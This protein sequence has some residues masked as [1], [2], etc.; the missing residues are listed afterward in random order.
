MESQ[1]N[2]HFGE[3]SSSS[4]SNSSAAYPANSSSD[5]SSATA[6]PYKPK[7]HN[8][9]K[10]D[11]SKTTPLVVPQ[12]LPVGNGPSTPSTPSTPSFFSTNAGQLVSWAAPMTHN[13]NLI[14]LPLQ[15]PQIIEER[16]SKIISDNEA[17]I[18][19]VEPSLQKKYHKITGIQRHLS[20]SSAPSCVSPFS[21]GSELPMQSNSKLAL[22][23]LK[24]QQ[25]QKQH[26]EEILRYQMSTQQP[27]NLIK[28]HEPLTVDVGTSVSST[29][30]RKRYLT[31]NPAPLV[32]TT[33]LQQPQEIAAEKPAQST[34]LVIPA[35]HPQNPE[36]SII[37]DLLL[38][39]KNFGAVD[40]ETGDGSYTCPT[41][42]LSFRGA[43]ILKYH[44]ICHC[45]GEDNILSRSAPISPSGTSSPYYPRS[46]SEKQS[47]ITLSQLA[48]SS[49]RAGSSRT[50]SSLQKLAKSQ[51]KP[52]KH[53]PDNININSAISAIKPSIHQ[54][55]V[56]K[57][58]LPS[59]GPLLGNT[60]LVDKRLD[61]EIGASSAKKQKVEFLDSKLHQLF[62]GDM[63]IF[64]EKMLQNS[65]NFQ[66]GS[67]IAVDNSPLE[68]IKE[69]SPNMMRQGL[70]GGIALELKK[71]SPTTPVGPPPVT[72]KLFVTITPT[73]AP[74]LT[75]NSMH[76]TSSKS[77]NHF[78]F[79]SSVTVY[80]P[81]TLPLM[82][83]AASSVIGTQSIVHGGRVIPYVPGIPGPNSTS[84]VNKH[85][86]PPPPVPVKD[87]RL[88]S[89]SLKQN[90]LLLSP[91]DP[92]QIMPRPNGVFTKK[93]SFNF[94][95]IAD[96]IDSRADKKASDEP[97]DIK[98]PEIKPT[99]PAF[100]RPNTL[101]LK[102]GTFTPKQHHGI[103]PTANT[104]PLISPET[105]RPSKSCVQMYLNGHAYTYLG[106]KSST[107]T[108]YC[109]V[110]KPQPV[111]IQNQHNLSMYSNWQIY[112]GNN[113]NILDLP[114]FAA[115][116]L[117][118]SR[119]RPANFSVAAAE[120]D[121]VSLVEM[122]STKV[123]TTVAPTNFQIQHVPMIKEEN[124]GQSS[125]SG[126]SSV[127]G[128]ENSEEYTYIR[129]RGRGKYVCEECGIRCKKPSMLKKHIRT[130]T[131]LRPYTCSHCE[132]R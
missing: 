5:N 20:T 126:G 27:L 51:L 121:I 76:F 34:Q 100:L 46:N 47:P 25:Q 71:E 111:Y 114:P 104:L 132:F 57:N 123:T 95:R 15:T 11:L 7:F 53:K 32:I 24:Q 65:K 61:E 38:N 10:L 8:Y 1:L 112:N 81:L 69:T 3:N 48:V 19:G 119:Q 39:S 4:S 120:A 87:K 23:L 35:S 60:R 21:T 36:G 85:D 130:H 56:I 70:S 116:S 40:G 22:A 26:D 74:T 55:A 101:P 30:P 109:T 72:P 97:D 50:P 12:P 29:A 68:G 52:L 28:V 105:P 43:D 17:I 45:Q 118:D 129:G 122:Q 82:S 62:G 42:K 64:H 9:K 117:Y 90:G 113:P 59:P 115:M 84:L 41:C 31:E 94:A 131:D 75:T 103:T 96:N 128:Y 14:K 106:L 73:L 79:P 107:K 110:N 54:Q 66:G 88:S 108:F 44:L 16:I 98:A 91:R 78:Q 124:T 93:K 49:L 92:S 63:K 80:N 86:L 127:T 33:N 83:T 99:K 125:S 18:D 67:M 58:P 2:G 13:R 102:P 37:K 89:P 6:K 77:N